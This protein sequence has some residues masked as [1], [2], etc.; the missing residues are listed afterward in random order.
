LTLAQW[1]VTLLLA[2]FA[3]EV[4][5]APT[6]RFNGGGRDRFKFHGR[7]PLVPPSEGGTIDPVSA[8]FSFDLLN[9]LGYIYRGELFPG[10]FV[11]KPN[12]HYEFRDL[13]ALEGTGS[14]NGVY[15]VKSRF[16]Q[17]AG[18]WYY[19][20]R[21]LVFADLSSATVPTMTVIL[22]QLDGEFAIT[23]EWVPTKFGWRL[24]LSR[25]E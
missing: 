1:A 16:R 21:I 25:F 17:Y 18:V 19:T 6:I 11:A 14:R 3:A 13:D 7:V 22:A 20:V 10:D 9:E 23:A 8:G 2:T 4:C 15:Q 12:L 5:A 24:P